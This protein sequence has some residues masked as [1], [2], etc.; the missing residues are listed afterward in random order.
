VFRYFPVVSLTQNEWNLHIAWRQL[1]FLARHQCQQLIFTQL[2]LMRHFL[3]ILLLS[4]VLGCECKFKIWLVCSFGIILYNEMNSDTIHVG[5]RAIKISEIHRYWRCH[6]K[7]V[8]THIQALISMHFRKLGAL[9]MNNK[10]RYRATA[11]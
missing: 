7:K 8:V 5:V 4:S 11:M 6:F 9:L 3:I 2:L 1:L 10:L